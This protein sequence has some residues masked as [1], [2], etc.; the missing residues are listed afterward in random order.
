MG[1]ALAVA[2]ALGANTRA[3]ASCLSALIRAQ[4]SCLSPPIRA[5]ASCLSVPASLGSLGSAPGSQ[6]SLALA[7]ASQGSWVVRDQGKVLVSSLGESGQVLCQV[8][9]LAGKGQGSL[10][11][12][13]LSCQG[14]GNS[15]LKAPLPWDNKPSLSSTTMV[16]VQRYHS[17]D[18][19]C[20]LPMLVRSGVILQQCKC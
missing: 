19:Q 8:L 3:Q 16:R 10:G 1:W 9:L 20:V 18:E 11:V 12:I 13:I 14:Q 4:G 6:A 7:L 5:Q 15:G 2:P 17:L